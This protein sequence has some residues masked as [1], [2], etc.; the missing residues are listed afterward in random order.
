MEL[1][2]EQKKRV[3]ANIGLVRAHLKNRIPT[4]GQPN[5]L[6]EYSDLFQ[7]G[8]C[9]LIRAAQTYRADAHGDFPAYA[10][11]R[12]RVAIHHA[13]QQSFATVRI[14]I[15]SNG[16]AGE[17]IRRGCESL[18]HDDPPDRRRAER[19]DAKTAATST[20]AEKYDRAVQAAK[21]DWIERNRNAPVRAHVA[22]R[23]VAER[24]LVPETHWRT[25]L[26]AI[27]LDAGVGKSTVL[28]WERRLVA[29]IRNRLRN[30]D[31][32]KKHLA[33][34]P[35]PGND[36]PEHRKN[37]RLRDRADSPDGDL[38]AAGLATHIGRAGP[39]KV[40]RQSVSRLPDADQETRGRVLWEL[41]EKV[42]FDPMELAG[43]LFGQLPDEQQDRFA[44]TLEACP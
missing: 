10:F 23:I 15:G 33:L 18:G 36:E 37:I 26:K 5:R 42:G 31:D 28:R 1:T 21:A 4:P 3:E 41:I 2:E 34:N 27:G 39:R 32:V 29:D 24:L 22:E 7:E 43:R 44:Q 14:P 20:I 11:P 9:G 8:C 38:A 12:I 25:S 19:D 17:A 13:L 16:K 30:D 40:G 6:R 35:V